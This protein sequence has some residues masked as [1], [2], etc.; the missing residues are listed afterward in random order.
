MAK[1]KKSKET[2]EQ[3]QENSKDKALSEMVGLLK[4]T[5]ANFE[6]FRKQTEKRVSDIQSVASK[7]IILQ[8]L[9]I[10]DN[11]HL[12]LKNAPQENTDFLQGVELIYS[13]FNS[14]LEDNGVETLTTEKKLFD[15]YY[16]EALMKTP[17]EEPENTIIEEFQKGYSLHGNVIRHA[18]VKVSAGK[19]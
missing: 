18:R 4:R 1:E 15:P 12:A 13:Q 5:Q 14:L 10:V 7:D 6:N 19:K 2:K 11:F 8:L 3:L 17:S 16:H 9:P